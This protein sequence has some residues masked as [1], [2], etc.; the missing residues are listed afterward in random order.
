[1]VGAEITD[2]NQV[3]EGG[4][5]VEWLKL[6]AGRD[7]F[8]VGFLH[9]LDHAGEGAEGHGFRSHPD[10]QVGEFDIDILKVLNEFLAGALYFCPQA[11]IP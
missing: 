6:I 2:V 7:A 10:R 11:T 5:E 4:D 9:A 1:M 8:N 3:V